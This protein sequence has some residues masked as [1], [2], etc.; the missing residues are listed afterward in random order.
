MLNSTATNILKD[1]R[2]N[3]I[4]F[5]DELIE[6]VPSEANFVIIRVFV[7]DEAPMIDIVNFIIQK[8][9]PIRDKVKRRDESFFL[10]NDILFAF[11]NRIKSTSNP[12]HFKNIWNNIFT[13]DDKAT[14]WLW[15]DQFIRLTDKYIECI[16]S[17]R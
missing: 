9:F 16:K 1:L 11:L 13:E 3:L 4:I 10:D 5:L 7:K 15:F 17:N 12:D 8:I 2:D 14:T 6:I